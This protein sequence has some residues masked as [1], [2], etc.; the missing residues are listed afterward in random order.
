MDGY[1]LNPLDSLVMLHQNRAF[2]LVLIFLVFN[3]T[4]NEKRDENYLSKNIASE[5]Q[6]IKFSENLI[7]EDKYLEIGKDVS[8]SIM[9]WIDNELSAYVALKLYPH[10]LDSIMC[11]NKSKNKFIT[12]IL[13]QCSIPECRQENI[14]YFY[15]IKIADKWY[16]YAGPTMVIPRDPKNLTTPTSFTKLHEIAMDNIF[17][18]YLKKNKETGEW[19]INEDFFAR[20]YE[21]D[22]YNFPFTTQEAWEESW[23]KL[24]REN[25]HKR[26]TTNYQP[27]Q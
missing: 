21:R 24:M 2:L 23:L 5:A 16:F 10:K 9:N 1:L 18:G 12:A 6:I 11:F 15:G 3:C 22:A 7:G 13:F 20:F 17:K 27:L 8:D 14:W 25:W 19:E 26:D 4:S